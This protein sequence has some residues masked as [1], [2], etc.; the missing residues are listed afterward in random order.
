M[1]RDLSNTLRSLDTDKN[2]SSGECTCEVCPE[3]F[4]ASV[5]AADNSAAL[6]A[7]LNHG[8]SLR[9]CA[10]IY[11]ISES[12]TITK[13]GTQITAPGMWIEHV[14]SSI[15]NV[16]NVADGLTDIGIAGLGID[17]R[18][19]L[20]SADEQVFCYGISAENP[21]RLRILDCQVKNC[22]EHGIAVNSRDS[23]TGGNPSF[24]ATNVLISGN[25]VYSCGNAGTLRSASI[26]LIGQK[27]GIAISNN[28]CQGCYWGIGVDDAHN[29]AENWDSAQI[30]ISNNIVLDDPASGNSDTRPEPTT[31]IRVETSQK[32]I[33]SGNIVKGRDITVQIRRIQTAKRLEDV[34]AC[35]NVVQGRMI[36]VLGG[37]RAIII[38]NNIVYQTEAYDPTSNPNIALDRRFRRGGIVIYTPANTENS[39]GI[40]VDDNVIYA[41]AQGIQV[42]CYRH[43]STSHLMNE[44]SVNNVSIYYMGLSAA[45]GVQAA[46]VAD[47]TSMISV[48]NIRALGG[49]NNG[50]VTLSTGISRLGDIQGNTIVDCVGSAISLNGNAGFEKITV[51]GNITSGNGGSALFLNAVL[52]DARTLVSVNNFSETV[53]ELG[54]ARR[55]GNVGLPD[56]QQ[57]TIGQ[58]SSVSNALN[59]IGKLT[60]K[61]VQESTTK[62]LYTAVGPA[63]TDSWRAGDGS[64]SVTPS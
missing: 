18:K 39:G 52:R 17:G 29:A 1:S 12:I 6:Q 54:Q 26:W 34:V 11:K 53:G 63:P 9:G 22:L 25:F 5:A 41:A 59:N 38:G 4:G 47:R 14:S 48:K 58:I 35:D 36:G 8:G 43:N 24:L 27:S 51:N 57:V 45:V 31:G 16:L 42:G 60:N 28:V 3:E 50:I 13:N 21:T 40:I 62:I 61:V 15:E 20:K 10:G 49:W 56:F 19:D 37:G 23:S 30:V 2:L 46:V 55:Y 32:A 33:V 7:W 44:I 64:G